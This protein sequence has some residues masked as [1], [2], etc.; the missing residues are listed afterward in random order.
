L[1]TGSA[2]NTQVFMID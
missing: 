2:V 1:Y